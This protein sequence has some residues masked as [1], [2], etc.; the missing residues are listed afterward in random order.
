[1]GG[2]VSLSGSDVVTA[3]GRVLHD[4]AS[5][6]ISKLTFDADLVNVM[7]AKSGNVI[8]GLNEAGNTA[9]LELRLLLGSSDDRFFNSLLAAQKADLSSFILITGSF[10]K[11][12]G[13]GAGNII[14]VIYNTF[15]GV[16][17]R[18]PDAMTDTAGSVDQSIAV[19]RLKFGQNS[20]AIM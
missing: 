12:V 16:I 6:T 18:F 9:S 10:V 11:R 5:G 13:D 4:F 7:S 2:S 3:S 15:G 14:N 17:T 1:M 8:Y 19:W 20:R